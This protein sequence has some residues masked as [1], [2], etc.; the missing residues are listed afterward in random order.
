MIN[1][2][3]AFKPNENELYE[4]NLAIYKKLAPKAKLIW[5]NFYTKKYDVTQDDLQ[6]YM[7]YTQKKYGYGHI[8]YKVLSNPFNFTEDEQAL[9]CDDG[10]LCFGYRKLGN[11]IT[12]YTD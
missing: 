12:I 11:L 5:L 4:E 10:N 2:G 6:N 8:T 9:I 1:T 3:W 7:C